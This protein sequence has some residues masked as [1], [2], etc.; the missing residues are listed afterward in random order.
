MRELRLDIEGSTIELP[1]WVI[2]TEYGTISIP[3]PHRPMETLCFTRHYSSGIRIYV[4]R[5]LVPGD[6]GRLAPYM[7]RKMLAKICEAREAQMARL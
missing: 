2:E 6:S 1:D 3:L 5:H 4:A 7:A